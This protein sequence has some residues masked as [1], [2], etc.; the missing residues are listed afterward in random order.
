[1]A[2]LRRDY[3]KF[4]D[5]QAEIVVV[6]PDSAPAFARYWQKESLPFVGLADPDHQVAGLYGQQVKLLRLGRLPALVLIDRRGRIRYQHYGDSMAEIPANADLLA[7]LD[8]LN[9]DLV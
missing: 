3:Q 9:E 7:M 2:Q 8:T 1:M 6:G 4:I 5:R